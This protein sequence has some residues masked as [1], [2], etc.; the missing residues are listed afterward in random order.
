MSH[1]LEIGVSKS[2]KSMRIATRMFQGRGGMATGAERLEEVGRIIRLPVCA[3]WRERG[4]GNDV[5]TWE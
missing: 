5:D 1:A 2:V 4:E 3:K